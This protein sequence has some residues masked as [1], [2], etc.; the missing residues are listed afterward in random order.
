MW[1]TTKPFW[2]TWK[3]VIMESG[4]CV[5]KNRGVYVIEVV[6]KCRYCPSEIFRD[7]INPHFEKRKYV[8]MTV[9]KG[10]GRELTSMLINRQW[11]YNYQELHVDI[12]KTV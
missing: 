4:L 3:M 5:S 1:S 8:S 10:I 12:V 2:G 6:N 9:T 7:Q 11:C